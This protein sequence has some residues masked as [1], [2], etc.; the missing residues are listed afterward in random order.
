MRLAGGTMAGNGGPMRTEDQDPKDENTNT[1]SDGAGR[2]ASGESEANEDGFESLRDAADREL[3]KNSNI[4]AAAFGQKAAKGDLNS[5]KF[6]VAV[7]VTDK[8]RPKRA[9]K[10]RRGL[11]VADRLAL[12][13]QWE[14]PPETNSETD[15][16]A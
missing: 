14:E 12:E 9:R 10:K 15:S 1:L 11:S 2:E 4:I 8:K 13:P 16:Q 5:A 7:A 6:L 3:G